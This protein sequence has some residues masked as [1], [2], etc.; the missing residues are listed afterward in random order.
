MLI[1]RPLHIGGMEQMVRFLASGLTK[2]GGVELLD[3]RILV[4]LADGV[5]RI[6]V[7]EN[8]GS[9]GADIGGIADVS[10]LL[11]LSAAVDAAAGT[12]HNFNKVVVRFTGLHLV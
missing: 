11:G 10:G 2:V 12:S 9:E 5:G 7:V 4:G 8:L 1:N 3:G 6:A